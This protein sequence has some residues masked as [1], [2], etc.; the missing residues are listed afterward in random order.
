[1]RKGEEVIVSKAEIKPVS[2]APQL[3]GLTKGEINLME[4]LLHHLKENKP[5][6]IEDIAEC[7]LKSTGYTKRHEE[8]F[9]YD[10]I[11]KR[12]IYHIVERT[13]TAKD[14]YAHRN[15][16]TWFKSNLGNCILKG[17]LLA[18]PVIEM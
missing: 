11:E 14:Y 16:R 17:K 4:M 15:G 2:F 13:Y 18:I 8:F 5:I 1:M 3:R 10:Q 6:K 7:Y 12:H 9:R